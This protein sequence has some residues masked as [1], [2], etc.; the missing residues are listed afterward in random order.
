MN[1]LKL[2]EA[3]FDEAYGLNNSFGNQ[4]K[5][6]LQIINLTKMFP[7]C[8]RFSSDGLVIIWSLCDTVTL[9]DDVIKY[10]LELYI[11]S[12]ETFRLTADNKHCSYFRPVKDI[13][14]AVQ[15][16]DEW[17]EEMMEVLY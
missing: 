10:E 14:E 5:I 6:A 7:D 15:C 1:K 2:T 16:V 3:E 13:E 9:P 17:Y 8:I 11:D 4:I 12:D